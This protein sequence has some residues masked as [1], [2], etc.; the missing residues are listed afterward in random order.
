MAKTDLQSA[1]RR[2]QST[3]AMPDREEDQLLVSRTLAGDREAFDSLVRRHFTGLYALLFRLAGNHEDAEDMT[4]ES[5]TKAYQSLSFYR[6]DAS[7]FTWVARIGI[8]LA[9]DHRRRSGHEPVNLD[10]ELLSESVPSPA[11]TP[12]G[13]ASRQE[14]SIQ[15]ADALRKLPDSLR[16]VTALR[17]L[18]D[19]DYE[20]VADIVGLRPGTVRT[21]VMRSRRLLLKWLAPWLERSPRP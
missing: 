2:T 7:F 16:T 1:P 8:H 4:Q 11:P 3:S 15:I 19:R 20:E 5:F 21:Q 18:E 9:H 6:G 10:L 13:D 14:L 12:S 17:L